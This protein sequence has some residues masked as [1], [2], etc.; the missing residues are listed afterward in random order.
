[1]MR[2]YMAVSSGE[3]RM[4]IGAGPP[5]GL[6]QVNGASYLRGVR[7]PL[8]AAF[9]FCA[10]AAGAQQ[11]P[12]PCAEKDVACV[13]EAVKNHPVRQPGFWRAAFARPLVERIAAAPPELI[14]FVTLDNLAHGYPNRPRAPRLSAGFLADVRRAFDAIPPAAKKRLESKLAGIY[15]ADDIGGTGFSD[16]IPDPSGKSTLGFVILD[17]SVLTARKANEWATWKE[18]SPFRPGEGWKLTARIEDGANDTQANAI[19]Y[20]LLH[21]LGHVLSIGAGVHPSWVVDP[22]TIKDTSGFPFFELSW[23]MQDGKAVTLYDDRFPQRKNLVFYFGAKLDAS[24]M[25]DTYVALGNTNF[26]TLYAATHFG[27]D[28]AE[29]FAN[30]VHV[31][32]MHKPFLI[33]ITENG[34]LVKSY[35]ACWSE[36]RCAAKKAF[37]EKFLQ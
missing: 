16:E 29:S 20:I 27:D 28:F 6:R 37:L 4:I 5:G 36:S 23:R 24:A 14:D 34:K 25:A 21:E 15:F 17:P 31:V 3:S 13:R 19:Q 30:Y 26:P 1:M 12:L 8:F 32:L 11:A 9:A 2:L 18:S 35:S 10:L 7:R 22:K 33:R